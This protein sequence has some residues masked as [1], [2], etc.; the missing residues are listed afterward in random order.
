MKIKKI[1]LAFTMLSGVAVAADELKFN[2][3]PHNNNQTYKNFFSM[4]DE[5]YI[6]DNISCPQKNAWSIVEAQNIFTANVPFISTYN[7]ELEISWPALSLNKRVGDTS[8]YFVVQKKLDRNLTQIRDDNV[9]VKYHPLIA[10]GINTGV[11]GHGKVLEGKFR[12]LGEDGKDLVSRHMKV[13]AH[14]SLWSGPENDDVLRNIITTRYSKSNSVIISEFVPNDSTKFIDFYNKGAKKILTIH[15]LLDDK[16]FEKFVQD[17]T[18]EQ[19]LKKDNLFLERYLNGTHNDKDIRKGL[20][21][22]KDQIVK[23]QA[24]SNQAGEVNNTKVKPSNKKDQ[25]VSKPAHN[26]DNEII[27]IND[28]NYG[29][30]D[31]S[32]INSANDNEIIDINDINYGGGDYSNINS[33]DDFDKVNHTKSAIVFFLGS[34]FNIDHENGFYKAISKKYLSTKFYSIDL[35]EV[36]NYNDGI[37]RLS[38]NLSDNKFLTG[39]LSDID[40]YNDIYNRLCPFSRIRASC[41]N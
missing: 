15:V 24:S 6:S 17:I 41:K 39:I 22:Y 7:S 14:D 25:V 23:F 30:G 40:T 4:P 37:N 29:G 13:N 34:G 3:K 35:G 2:I 10:N 11:S 28:I 12:L 20:R 18:K 27:D 32:N 21:L 16:H 8:I 19:N 1:V 33:A 38:G 26:L 36:K 9:T 5:R 31:Y